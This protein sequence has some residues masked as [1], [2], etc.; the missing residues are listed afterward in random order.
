[1]LKNGP[2]FVFLCIILLCT[3]GTKNN[4]QSPSTDFKDFTLTSLTGEEYTLSAL[5][6]YVILIDFWTTW[7]PPCR[8]TI[9]V[10]ISLYDK[11]KD[12]GFI[13]LGISNESKSTLTA[14]RDE[15]NINYPILI[16]NQNVMRT[17]G[18][19][20]I[21]NMFIFN[22]SGKIVKHQVGFSPE[23]EAGFNVLIDS[24]LKE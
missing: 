8:S 9:P 3:C 21:P 2:F 4:T 15:I 5:K 23:L 24:L 14:F 20:S 12:Q 7:C 11:Y 13:V 22:K 1:M 18:V 17:Y 16:D 19:Q 6:G 10:L